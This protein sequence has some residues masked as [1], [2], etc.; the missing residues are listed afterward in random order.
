MTSHHERRRTVRVLGV[1]GVLLHTGVS[2]VLGRTT[3]VSL[4]GFWFDGDTVGALPNAPIAVQLAL[5]QGDVVANA[6]VRRTGQRGVGFQFTQLGPDALEVL[7]RA[8]A[9]S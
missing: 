6:V 9:G 8:I 3:D 1:F 7:H 5:P 4:G 2:P